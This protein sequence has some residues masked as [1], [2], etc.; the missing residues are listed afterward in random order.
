MSSVDHLKLDGHI[1]H[2][3]MFLT[4][5]VRVGRGF[6]VY[7]GTSGHSSIGKDHVL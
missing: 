4:G 2:L 5:T 7:P 6:S 1:A 3:D